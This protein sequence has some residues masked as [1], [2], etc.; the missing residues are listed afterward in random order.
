LEVVE[1]TKSPISAILIKKLIILITILAIMA[2]PKLDTIK[3]F[4]SELTSMSTA[5]LM[6]SKKIPKVKNVIGK[7]SAMRSGLMSVFAN[8]RRRADTMSAPAD[9]NLTPLNI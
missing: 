5:P 1:T 9:S 2:V 7:V 3:P 8:P 6:T 4:T